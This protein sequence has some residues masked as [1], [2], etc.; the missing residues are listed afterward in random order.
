MMLCTVMALAT[1][2]GAPS[3]TAFMTT[4][5]PRTIANPPR[6]RYTLPFATTAGDDDDAFQDSTD[7]DDLPPPAPEGFDLEDDA[8]MSAEEIE[9]MTVAQLKQQLRLRGSKVSGTKSELTA[10]LLEGKSAVE[11]GGGLQEGY[12][13]YDRP[14]VSKKARDETIQNGKEVKEEAKESQRVT[15]ARARG[16][17]IADVT[18][19]VEVEEVGSEFR[20]SDRPRANGQPIDVEVQDAD[21][22][23]KDDAEESAPSPEVWGDDAK[24]VDD[25]EG[26]SV[27]V[28]GLSRTVIE[29]KGSN[30]TVVQAYAV[31]SRE[32][33]ANFLRGGEAAQTGQGDDASKTT[34]MEEEVYA[35]QRKRETESKRGM[36]RPDEVEGEEDASDPGAV[37]NTMERDYGDWGAYTPT[38][39][40]KSSTEV[41]GVLLLSDVYGP[42]TDNTQALADKIAFECQ[43]VVVL[44]PDL[45]RGRPWTPHPIADEEGVERNEHGQSYEEWRATHPESRVDV[46]VRAAAA[47]LR[48]KYAVSSIAV[49]GTCY[50][51]GRALEAAAG[52]YAG[53]AEAY[54]EDA[55]GERQAPPHVDPIACVAW[56]PTR[57]DA[58]KL[59]G[60]ENEGFRT[61]ASGKD[62]SVAVMA[63]FAEDDALAGATPEDALLLKECL[64]EDPRIKD[65]MV[66]I[67]PGQKHG[68]AHAN[69]GADREGS[70]SDGQGEMDR[71]LGEDFGSMD[72]LAIGGD[73]EVA[74]LLST[75]WMETYTRVFLPT[76]GTP[77]RFDANERWSALEMDGQPDD[78]R[79]DVR[80]E[81]DDAIAKY[82]D[83]DIDLGRMS[84]SASPLLEGPGATKMEEIEAEREKARQ[85]ILEKYDISD[86]DDEET[87]D[88]KIMQAAQD[89]AFE[90]L[91]LDA[92]LD[93]AGDAYW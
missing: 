68:F 65:F 57:Y 69:L 61:F 14:R 19:F 15:E 86:D 35:L 2:M 92:Q 71:F 23:K 13:R 44:V 38:G 48:E 12:S 66:K 10:R 63:V 78:E 60:K 81:L 84:Q 76:V 70:G 52:W 1:L 5:Y 62:R 49:W 16:A 46:D 11:V 90:G 17:D 8:E 88:R 83:L 40:Q 32:S 54:Y 59:F 75:A 41:Q 37:Y 85:M 42:Y 47:V 64:D 53:G 26:R 87:W 72:P 58:R 45:F 82:E 21:D 22:A 89:G 20:S 51:G 77:V 79:Q 80:A 74:C 43:P 6:W 39:A 33:L 7:T 55:L 3:A 30:G 9:G 34:T 67:F 25:Y 36:I 27:V 24:I 91:F 93:E 31:G 50:G 29:Y 73:A 28:D 4:R 18:D 56:Y